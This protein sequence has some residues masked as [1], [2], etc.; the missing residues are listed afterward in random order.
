MHRARAEPK[1][2]DGGDSGFFTWT[3]VTVQFVR[4]D[5]RFSPTANTVHEGLEQR[6]IHV[7]TVLP[8][9]PVSNVLA[10]IVRGHFYDPQHEI[11]GSLDGLRL[12][13]DGH[14]AS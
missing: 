9:P 12:I 10:N 7:S 3:W 6:T 1:Q 14:G 5:R 2:T 13:L 8:Q 11:I 4:P